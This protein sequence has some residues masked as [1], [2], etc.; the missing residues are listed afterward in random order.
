MAEPKTHS[1]QGQLDE[2]EIVVLCEDSVLYE[3]PY[4]GQHGISLLARARSE[5][6]SRNIL[7]DVGQNPSALLGNFSLMNI[8]PK[9]VDG[10]VITH[11]HYDHTRG[12]AEVLRAIGKSDLPVV[13][14]PKLFRL[15]FI[16][17][18]H[19]RHV[20]VM[21]GDSAER[22]REAGAELFLTSDPL[23]LMPGLFTTGEVKRQTEYEEVGIGG[24]STLEDGH[25]KK[26]EMPDDL[27]IV[28]CV[29]GH[30]PVIMTG[31]S[32]AGIVN[33]VKQVSSM[34]DTTSFENVLGGFHLVEASEER[35]KKTCTGLAAFD[36][37]A[38]MPGHC[39]GFRAQAALYA[40]FGKAFTPLQTGMHI[41][42]SAL[43]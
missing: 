37:K 21:Q 19:L 9:E 16:T 42:I 29:R 2:L 25:L 41:R 18:P 12:L 31:C 8:D 13:A 7:M 15:N 34:C 6:I 23:Q 3:S 20:G 1:P 33:I 5:G 27:S 24:L 36:L 4:L 10:I 35:I 30:A 28:A 38:V 39:T 32:H 14:H 11:C 40:S 26:D 43:P 22:L 17:T